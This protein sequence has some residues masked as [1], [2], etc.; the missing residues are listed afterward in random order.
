MILIAIYAKTHHPA[1]APQTREVHGPITSQ[2]IREFINTR[3]VTKS[4]TYDGI[5]RARV[6]P[7]PQRKKPNNPSCSTIARA[8]LISFMFTETNL[9]SSSCRLILLFLA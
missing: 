4:I 6:S 9:F 1:I 2:A 8:S 3:Y 5:S 7:I